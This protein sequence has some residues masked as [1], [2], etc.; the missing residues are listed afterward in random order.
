MA[1]L[2]IKFKRYCKGIYKGEGFL[3]EEFVL[4]P[5]KTY[6]GTFL[7]FDDNRYGLGGVLFS[8]GKGKLVAQSEKWDWLFRNGDLVK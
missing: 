4:V 3:G 2:N 8:V 7:V 1:K 5:G 6:K